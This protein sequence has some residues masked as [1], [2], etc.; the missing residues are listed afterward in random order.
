MTDIGWLLPS[1]YA[2]AGFGLGCLFALAIW[3]AETRKARWFR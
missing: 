2:A 3:L 1:T